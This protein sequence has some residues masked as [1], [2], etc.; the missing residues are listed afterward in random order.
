L[1]LW[2]QGTGVIPFLEEGELTDTAAWERMAAAFEGA[3]NF[4]GFAFWFN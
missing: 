3:L 1:V 2:I 4:V